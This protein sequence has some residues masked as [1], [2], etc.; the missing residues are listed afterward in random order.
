MPPLA[1][2]GTNRLKVISIDEVKLI[3]EGSNEYFHDMPRIGR[4]QSWKDLPPRA[5]VRLR[6]RINHRLAAEHIPMVDETVVRWRV[7]AKINWSR[8]DN[9]SCC[10]LYLIPAFANPVPGKRSSSQGEPPVSSVF[11]TAAHFGLDQLQYYTPQ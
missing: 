1:C 6:E 9:S 11:T 10:F 5:Q 3:L 8:L 7:G 2:C 4:V